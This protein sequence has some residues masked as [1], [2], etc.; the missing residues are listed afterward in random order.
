MAEPNN[1][2]AVKKLLSSTGSMA[3]LSLLAAL[4]VFSVGK[5]AIDVVSTAAV[6]ETKVTVH[7]NGDAHKDLLRP[8]SYIY[9]VH[10][11]FVH[12]VFE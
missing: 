3:L 4:V 12:A 5:P 8:V 9:H 11:Q 2:K 1:L 7:M 6:T 10:A